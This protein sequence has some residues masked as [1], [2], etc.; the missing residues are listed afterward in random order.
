MANVLETRDRDSVE[1]C[2]GYA[3]I[4]SSEQ[5]A[6]LDGSGSAHNGQKLSAD[7]S[8]CK[9]SMRSGNRS[10][11]E[12]PTKKI[13]LD[14]QKPHKNAPSIITKEGSTYSKG[15]HQYNTKR[16][17]LM[18]ISNTATATDH[19]HITDE[20]MTAASQKL[21]KSGIVIIAFDC[22][23]SYIDLGRDDLR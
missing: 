6:T 9:N 23:L 4:S 14:E 15:R 12:M 22:T 3:R 10:E 21:S 20:N 19:C 16:K 11:D 8:L 13:R 5:V 7:E 2:S 17:R 1:I 18:A